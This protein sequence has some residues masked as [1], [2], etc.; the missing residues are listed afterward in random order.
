MS[1]YFI[2]LSTGV[3]TITNGT[4]RVLTGPVLSNIPISKVNIGNN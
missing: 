1:C 2:V 3:S 4:V